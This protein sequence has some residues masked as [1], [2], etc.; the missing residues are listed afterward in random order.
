MYKITTS[1]YGFKIAFEGFIKAMEMKAWLAEA[2]QILSTTANKKFAVLIDMRKLMPLPSD[3]QVYI[4]KGQALFRARGMVRSVVILENPI[5]QMQFK[6]IA[7]ETGIYDW[8]R[9]IFTNQL[10]NWQEVAKNWLL[11][12]IDPDKSEPK[13]LY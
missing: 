11:K 6:R 5:I 13:L 10:D 4:Q 1:N 2:E 7:K 12:G 9:Y 8:E 3:S